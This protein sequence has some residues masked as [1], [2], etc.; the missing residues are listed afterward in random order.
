MVFTM[1]L[2]G[3]SAASRIAARKWIAA[4]YVYDSPYPESFT[5][6]KQGGLCPHF[7][8]MLAFEQKF[9]PIHFK[10]FDLVRLLGGKTCKRAGREVE[11]PLRAIEGLVQ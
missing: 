2:P 5:A 6:Q 10:G 11:G 8:L 1:D 3:D 7:Y 9:T 4:R